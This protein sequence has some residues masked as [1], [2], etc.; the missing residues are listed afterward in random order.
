[1][2]SKAIFFI[3]LF[4]F[5]AQP[6]VSL[7]GQSI[8]PNSSRLSESECAMIA[9][10]IGNPK[11]IG[12]EIGNS[13]PLQK[14][15]KISTGSTISSGAGEQ[16]DLA[17]PNGV[18]V[19][20]LEHSMLSIAKS[21]HDASMSVFSERASYLTQ[22]FGNFSKTP[23][24]RLKQA[25][26]GSPISKY[27][28]LLSEGTIVG[29]SQNTPSGSHLEIHTPIGTAEIKGT[30]W[31]C[32]VSLSE[33]NHFHGDIQTTNGPIVFT[34]PDGSGA[35]LISAGYS[36][37]FRAKVVGQGKVIFDVLNLSPISFENAE[38]F[39]AILSDMESKR[40]HFNPTQG[41]DESLLTSPKD[42]KIPE[43][44]AALY[45][46]RSDQVHESDDSKATSLNL[47]ET[48]VSAETK[49]PQKRKIANSNKKN[50][51]RKTS[52][53]DAPEMPIA[54]G[55]REVEP[56]RNRA[57]QQK[58]HQPLLQFPYKALAFIWGESEPSALYTGMWSTHFSH[59]E[60]VNANWLTAINYEGFFLGT[61]I[62]SYRNRSFAAGVERQVWSSDDQKS[63]N[64]SLGYRLGLM[65]GYRER[66]KMYFGD[67]P[68]IL[69]PQLFANIA[70]QHVGLQ[71]GYSW[72]VISCGLFYRF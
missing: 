31:R 11:L 53:A 3:C 50:M 32:S 60:D 61:F 17:V 19:R 22:Q 28:L 36:L 25:S 26:T 51:T 58:S 55:F 34:K 46:P 45:T 8:D 49:A 38:A 29:S 71:I 47:H 42:A 5:A 72:T 23:R 1:M 21:P 20:L 65:T 13:L 59:P 56:C 27:E 33:E 18:F 64:T 40:I 39:F 6:F 2:H 9:D 62:N 66:F 52:A 10:F 54:I 30:H 4:V 35:V 15:Q 24:E 43:A 69:F 7:A 44:K 63:F 37:Q 68:I 16:V 41:A 67:S 14:E 57:S 70:Y 48:R 12:K